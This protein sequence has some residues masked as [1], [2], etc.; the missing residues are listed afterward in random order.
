MSAKPLSREDTVLRL[1]KGNCE[2]L[3]PILSR[4]PSHDALRA[5][6]EREIEMAREADY[7]GH[8][9]NEEQICDR[10]LSSEGGSK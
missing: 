7:D 1:A 6:L 5:M 8:C 3:E 4:A 2:A 10:I 9:F